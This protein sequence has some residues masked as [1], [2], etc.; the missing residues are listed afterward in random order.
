MRKETDC[1]RRT[2]TIHTTAPLMLSLVMLAVTIGITACSSPGGKLTD[3]IGKTG[4]QAQETVQAL[5]AANQVLSGPDSKAIPRKGDTGWF[6]SAKPAYAYGDA[7]PDP[8]GTPT[9]PPPTP[10]R[11]PTDVQRLYETVEPENRTKQQN[12]IEALRVQW[13]PLYKAAKESYT[14]LDE[15]IAYSEKYAAEYFGQQRKHVESLRT[16]AANVGTIQTAMQETYGKQAKYYEGWIDSAYL[17]R[18]QCN[19]LLDNMYNVNVLI[20]FTS[21]AA[22]FQSLLDE[23]VAIPNEIA[24]LNQAMANFQSQ[25]EDILAELERPAA[26]NGS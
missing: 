1:Q 9:E 20:E 21:D 12:D 23:Q 26:R 4:E 2:G 6:F 3:R 22:D 14:V 8:E 19:D 10:T 13:G 11:T 7:D 25:T 16:D 24:S 5:L 18:N 17:L 15:H